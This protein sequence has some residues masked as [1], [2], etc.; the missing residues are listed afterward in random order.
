M[1]LKAFAAG[2]SALQLSEDER[3]FFRE[4]RPCGLILF[5]RNCESPD[6]VRRLA[7]DAAHAVGGDR[8]MVMV[9]QEGG[10]VRR[11]RP[12]HWR[13][14]PAARSFGTFYQSDPARGLEAARLA[15]RLIAE[16]LRAC[17]ITVNAAPVLDVPVPGAHD[18]IGDRAYGRDPETVTALGRAVGEGLKAGGVIPVIKHI[19]GHGRARA[20]SHE[21]LPVIDTALGE[22]EE[23]DFRP[24][25]ALA[26]MPAAMTA[27]VLLT[28]LDR[29]RPASVSP[30][31]ISQVIRGS[32]G[33]DG[34]LMSDDVSMKALEGPIASRA[35]DVI[36]AGCDI[37]L[38]CNG[39]MREMAAVAEVVPELAGK[40][41]A[42]LEAAL[43]VTERCE[44]FDK[45]RAAQLL[46]EVAREPAA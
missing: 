28:A 17:R 33:F 30:A 32:I 12:P 24:F 15:A 21:S 3:A 38:H 18:I 19:P 13:D 31:I 43:E 14:Y 8:F 9:D 7:D 37:V 35:R 36:E 41:L 10:R 39:E 2:C 42:R 34:L 29:T 1:A 5:R 11:L 4:A 22:L 45:T 40:S 6:Q 26:H 25:A 20:D 27:H 44:P 46:A 23:S 16:D